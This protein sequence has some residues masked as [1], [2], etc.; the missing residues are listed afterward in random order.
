MRGFADALQSIAVT[1]WAGAVWAIGFIAAP[2]LFSRL[3]DRAMAGM[4]AGKLFTI[5]AWIGIACAV[6]LLVL[7]LTRHGPACLKQ[8]FFWVVL[9]MFAVVLAGHFGVQP[10]LEGLRVQAR[11]RE[12]AED[13]LLDR[14]MTWHG[15]A[16]VLYIIQSVLAVALV[17]LHGR[18]K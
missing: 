11:A 16:S 7:R 18:G 8:G 9:V 13:I 17:V 2:I 12:L 3:T 5:V 4:V 1:L 10:V 15:I 6:Y 14:F